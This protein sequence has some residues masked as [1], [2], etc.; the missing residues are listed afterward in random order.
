M[1]FM[2]LCTLQMDIGRITVFIAFFLYLIPGVYYEEKRLEKE[3]G[4]GSSLFLTRV[5]AWLRLT[6]LLGYSLSYQLETIAIFMRA[7][8]GHKYLSEFI[9]CLLYIGKIIIL[10]LLKLNIYIFSILG[11]LNFSNIFLEY[12]LC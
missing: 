4:N 6:Y 5:S 11:F 2:L 9:D 10:T 1:M 3:F 7:S 8:S 12:L